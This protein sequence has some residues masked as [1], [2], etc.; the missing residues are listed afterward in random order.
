MDS[1][2]EQ[3][4][5]TTNRKALTVNLDAKRY[6]TF[7]EIG[8]G[9]E[10]CRNFFQAG[11]AA[12]T[13]A[14]TMSAYDMT[15]SDSIYGKSGRYVSRERLQKMI[16]HEYSLLVER[17]SEEV[18]NE[19]CFFA[20]AN[21]MK[22]KSYRGGDDTHGWM[23]IRFQLTPNAE[24]NEIILHTRMWDPENVQQ[25]HAVGI[26]GTNLI[27]G[28]S[29]LHH[30]IEELIESLADNVGNDRIEVDLIHFSGPD[31]SHVDNRIANLHLVR[32]GL[33]NAVLFSPHGEITQPSEAI[34]KKAVLVERGSFRP[35]TRV[36]IDMLKCSGAQFVQEP[37]VQGKDVLVMAELTMNNLLAS[38]KLD[39][40]DFLQR[41]DT[42]GATGNYV[43]ISNYFEFY[44]LT[45]YFRRYT[46]EMIGVVMGINNLLEV[47]NERYYAHLE[48]GILESFGRLFKN[49]VK[50]YIYP[51]KQKAYR[52][53]LDQM[54]NG[55]A[56]H[57]PG[58]VSP[59]T[60]GGIADE[61]LITCNNLRID[62]KLSNLYLHLLEN[63][64]IEH[65][66]GIDESLL[67][68]FSRDILKAIADNDPSWK[69]MVPEKAVA[70][71]KQH[72]FF[73]YRAPSAQ[74]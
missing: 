9:Q 28:A 21:T 45:S 65:L 64:Y 7:A 57:E 50:L 37:S 17:L 38:G 24:P 43:L 27:Y 4:L 41:I 58:S 62:S 16:D 33:T 5:L 1:P 47:F 36:N 49:A 23:G 8:A 73:G 14:K 29:Y 3:E 68:I 67:E 15:F 53:Y 52:R 51:M 56:T 19:R 70:V 6:G 40:D 42:I 26:L 11:G 55:D 66:R 12:G 35:I 10:T 30:N 13:I 72:Q 25:Q 39:Y 74:A 48:G 31:F 61:M 60:I 71:I 59:Q 32:R 18:G 44:R 34:Y 20:Y 46:K 22:A 69:E 63:G 2:K 54:K